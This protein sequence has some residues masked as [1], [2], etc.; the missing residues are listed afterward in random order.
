ML[1]GKPLDAGRK[2]QRLEAR[3]LARDDAER[4]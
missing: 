3:D 1:L 2:P 4:E